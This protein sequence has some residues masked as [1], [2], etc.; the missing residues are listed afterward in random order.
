MVVKLHPHQL[1]ALERLDN[2]KILVGGVGSGKSLT[3]VEYYMRKEADADVYVITTPKKR[4]SLDWESEFAK[5]GVGPHLNS[6]V[7]GTLV[8]DSWNNIGRYTNVQGAFFI[9]DEQRVVGTGSWSKSFVQIAKRNR[10]ILLSATPGDTWLDYVPVF[11]A[12]GFY[13]NRTDFTQQ[14]VVYSPYSKFPKVDRYV[15]VG[16]LVRLR[17]QILVPMPYLRHTVRKTFVTPVDYDKSLMDKVVRERWHVFEQRPLKAVAELFSVSRRVANSDLSRTQT[18]ET[19]LQEHPK[20]IIFYNFNY[21]LEAL[22][23]LTTHL[24]SESILSRTGEKTLTSGQNGSSGTNENLKFEQNSGQPRKSENQTLITLPSLLELEN[25]ST[26]TIE[27]QTELLKTKAEVKWTGPE[28]TTQTTKPLEK[29]L[30]QSSESSQ[31]INGSGSKNSASD[32]QLLEDAEWT[33]T[34]KKNHLLAK[35]SE[36]ILDRT[37]DLMSNLVIAEWNGQKHEP[38]PTSNSWIYLVQYTSGAEGWNCITTD[39]IVF[40]SLNYSYKIW[41]QAY[42]RIDRLN[43]PFVNLN[44]YVLKGGS[45]ID[46]AIWKSLRSKKSFNEKSYEVSK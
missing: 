10:W 28:K 20:M 15:A 39:T 41:E 2:A 8:V 36:R 25:T 1:K 30:K 3:A 13:K 17:N 14:H 22:R 26:L 21:E 4:D 23:T 38:L 18:I 32:T 12:N 29:S 16:K 35:K 46:N 44:Y 34:E 42:G 31:P 7:A 24:V 45:W 43:T 6:T 37:P 9:F 5:A 27:Q 19:L 33:G 11:V 40:F